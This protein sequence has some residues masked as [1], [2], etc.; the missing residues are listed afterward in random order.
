MVLQMDVWLDSNQ[1]Q[2]VPYPG[3]YRRPLFEGCSNICPVLF[4]VQFAL[5][6]KDRRVRFVDNI[7]ITYTMKG[8][9][10]V[11][12]VWKDNWRISSAEMPSSCICR[13]LYSWVLRMLNTDSLRTHPGPP[14]ST[15][16]CL[17]LLKASKTL[18]SWAHHII[19][20]FI[21]CKHTVCLSLP[22]ER[23]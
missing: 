3:F 6:A 19:L 20:S 21:I 11:A 8:L 10:A 16:R 18:V 1:T 2:C 12:V 14:V 9:R 23:D 7:N 17:S 13:R 4:W 22:A 15:K 5:R